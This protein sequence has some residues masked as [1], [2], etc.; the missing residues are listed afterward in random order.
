MVIKF[1]IKINELVSSVKNSFT[2]QIKTPCH[3]K[4]L[5]VFPL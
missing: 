4:V 1:K 3:D 5:K 2:A